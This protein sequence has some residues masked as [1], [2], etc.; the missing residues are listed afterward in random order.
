[1]L[2]FRGVVLFHPHPAELELKT[3]GEKTSAEQ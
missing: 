2:R 3:F 1:M